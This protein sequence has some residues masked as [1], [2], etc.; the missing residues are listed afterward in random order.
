MLDHAARRVAAPQPSEVWTVK[1]ARREAKGQLGRIASEGK[2]LKNVSSTI[3]PSPFGTRAIACED[4]VAGLIPSCVPTY[5]MPPAT[6]VSSKWLSSG[7]SAIYYPR[8]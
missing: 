6:S 8:P 7:M 4:L 5:K 1:A 2:P 3:E